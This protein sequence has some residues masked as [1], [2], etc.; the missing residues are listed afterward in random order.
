V[1][2]AYAILSGVAPTVLAFTV[3]FFAATL[4]FGWSAY[5]SWFVICLVAGAV[6]TIA[7][8]R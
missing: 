3:G 1:P 4:P 8:R 5:I 7:Q 6:I 2:I